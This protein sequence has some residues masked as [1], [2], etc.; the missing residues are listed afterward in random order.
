[1]FTRKIALVFPLAIAGT[2]LPLAICSA[3]P[4]ASSAQTDSVA[5]AARKA[6]AEKAKE[7]SKSI[8]VFT[9]EDV[10]N[11]KG[12]V[13]VVGAQ[14]EADAAKTADATAAAKPAATA[15]VAAPAND[16]ATW[17]ARFAEARKKLSDDA[18]ELDI[19]QRELNLK[20]QQYYSD[21]NVAL[22][23]QNNRDDLKN[24]QAQID[25]KK[26]AVDKDKQAISD[27]EEELRKAGGDPGWA[28]D[29]SQTPAPVPAQPPSD[30]QPK[31]P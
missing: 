19:L 14:P 2:L 22:H 7:P 9:D 20:Q 25:V 28:R 31:N 3:A 12:V 10:P 24:D 6:R 17:R 16:E 18:K 5:D 1:M 23:Q 26:E 8:K 30:A 21:P 13:S 4:Q 29:D 15:A 11:L 27:L